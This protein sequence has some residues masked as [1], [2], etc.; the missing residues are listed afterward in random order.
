MPEET[1]EAA[2]EAREEAQEAQPAADT[3]ETGTEEAATDWKAEYDRVLAASRK[4]ERRAKDNAQKAK[5]YDELQKRSEAEA[6][7]AE[8]ATRRAEEAEARV[9][10]LERRAEREAQVAEAARE[11][12]VSAAVLSRMAGEG[13]E[14]V[15]ANAELLASCHI[16]P[17]VPDAGGK[18]A[19]A[20]QDVESIRDPVERV[21]ARAA[22][23]A[24]NRR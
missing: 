20:K 5:G 7:R 21:R 23:L 24:R 3:S 9:A 4:W 14:A 16:Y 15:R 13:S 17:D 1:Q 8:E 22:E 19:P 2:T 6:G 18:P 12:G 10:E 11:Y